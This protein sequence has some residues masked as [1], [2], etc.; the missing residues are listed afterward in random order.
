MGQRT[1][2]RD[3]TD[4]DLE[5]PSG[6]MMDLRKFDEIEDA[7][8]YLNEIKKVP[9][10]DRAALLDRWIDLVGNLPPKEGDALVIL[11]K[12]VFGYR[13]GTATKLVKK[14]ARATLATALPVEDFYA[15][16]PQ[17]RYIYVPTRDLWPAT[18]VNFRVKSP[19]PTMAASEWIGRNRPVD[20]MTWAPGEPLLIRDRMTEE[21]GWIDHPG[22]A[23]FNLYRAPRE[24]PGDA[25]QAG[26]WLKHVRRLYPEDA[27]HI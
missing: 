6:A 10:Q 2:S 20:Q 5:Q 23:V 12:P 4:D 25:Q 14:V 27:A 26:V 18:T 13:L 9:K 22:A 3:P 16:M 21:G 24:L 19:D 17:H 1:A 8:E 7:L 11:A 15:Y